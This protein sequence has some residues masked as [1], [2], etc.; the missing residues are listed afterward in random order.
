MRAGK[1]EA[2]RA[3]SD[4]AVCCVGEPGWIGWMVDQDKVAEDIWAS[5][6]EEVGDLAGAGE[7]RERKAWG[8]RDA[9]SGS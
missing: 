9:V 1:D 5:G 2:A 6:R 4:P 3:P 7:E 8:D